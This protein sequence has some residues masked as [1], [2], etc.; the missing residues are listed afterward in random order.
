MSFFY[1][2][3]WE[4]LPKLYLRRHTICLMSFD[5]NI[6]TPILVTCRRIVKSYLYKKAEDMG[7]VSLWRF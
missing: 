4:F 7:F 1:P 6:I 3:P 5:V 2:N